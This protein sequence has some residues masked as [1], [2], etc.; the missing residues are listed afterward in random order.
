MIR[1]FFGDE[2]ISMTFE[3]VPWNC[4]SILFVWND[5]KCS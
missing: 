3:V 2:L 5:F 1:V 4:T